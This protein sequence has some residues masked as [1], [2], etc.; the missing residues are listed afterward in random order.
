M[1]LNAI[2]DSI[3]RA[4]EQRGNGTVAGALALLAVLALAGAPLAVFGQAALQPKPLSPAEAAKVGERLENC[5]ARRR[6]PAEQDSAALTAEFQGEASYHVRRCLA[7]LALKLGQKG[8]ATLRLA[9]KDADA[10]VRQTAVDGL[11]RLRIPADSKAILEAYKT[12]TD[13]GVKA[14]VARRL[15]WLKG[16]E[17]ADLDAVKND[18][19]P[20]VRELA[21]GAKTRE[22]KRKK[23]AEALKKGKK[24]KK[25]RKR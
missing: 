21:A 14:R 15:E 19:D 1:N 22:D 8:R 25:R 18:A 16:A 12:E 2:K 4:R 9:L 11:I 17:P 3:T 5:E 13:K 24:A 6:K 23:R 7:G 10:Q 20:K